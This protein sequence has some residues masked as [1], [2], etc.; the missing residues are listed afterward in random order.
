VVIGKLFEAL[1]VICFGLAWP[2]SIYKS[3]KSRSTGG[4][5]LSFLIIILIGYAAGILHVIL[6]YDGFNWIII[7]YGMNAMMVGID[8]CLY[9][10][11]KRLETR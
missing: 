10:R 4:K 9:F 5:S 8:T 2:A 11:N 1:M 7:L 3:W 6:D